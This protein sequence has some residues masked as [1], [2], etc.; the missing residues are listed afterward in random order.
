MFETHKIHSRSCTFF[1]VYFCRQFYMRLY[2]LFILSISFLFFLNRNKSATTFVMSRVFLFFF[3][4]LYCLFPV[5]LSFMQAIDFIFSFRYISILFIPLLYIS[6]Q[7]L[8]LLGFL[9]AG[10][11]Y[12][13]SARLLLFL[14]LDAVYRP[15]AIMFSVD[16]TVVGGH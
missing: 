2:T 15:T 3:F 6:L 11:I 16:C 1:F 12:S 8:Q 7:Y 9:V 4:P 13:V 14:A 10:Y 5:S